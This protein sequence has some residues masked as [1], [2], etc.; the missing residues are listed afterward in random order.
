MDYNAR[1]EH[2]PNMGATTAPLRSAF[3]HTITTRL[4]RLYKK[5]F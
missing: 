3:E 2:I 1:G 4:T 5:L